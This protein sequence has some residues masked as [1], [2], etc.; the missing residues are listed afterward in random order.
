MKILIVDDDPGFCDLVSFT[1]AREG[2]SVLQAHNSEEALKIWRREN[3]SLILLDIHLSPAHGFSFLRT[4]RAN[5][6]TPIMMVSASQDEDD[7]VQALA[8][9][10]DEYIH[11][12]LQPRVFIARVKALLRRTGLTTSQTQT[13]YQVAGLIFNTN[14]R[15]VCFGDGRVTFLTVLETRLFQYLLG[16]RS[17]ILPYESLISHVWGPEG[18][19]QDMLRQL[20]RRLRKKVDTGSADESLIVNLPGQGYGIFD[21]K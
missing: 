14:T 6:D 12:P 18:G 3:P 15:Q 13:E 7:L 11:K 21:R 9:G 19:D 20:V 5:G 16:N 1:L 4:V 2:F 8:L 10:A 17:Q